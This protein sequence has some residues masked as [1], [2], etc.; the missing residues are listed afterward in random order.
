MLGSNTITL[1]DLA[2]NTTTYAFT[3]DNI[4]PVGGLLTMKTNL[5]PDGLSVVSPDANGIY[6][7]TTPLS[8]TGVDVFKSLSA[9][10]TDDNLNIANVSV[11]VDGNLNGDMAYDSS[12]K[13]WN[14]ANQTSI[15]TFKTGEHNLVATFTDKAG[16]TKTLTARFTTDNTAPISGPLTM[17][18]KLFPDG[19]TITSPIDG[20]YTLPNLS[21]DGVDQ[22]SSLSV[23][24]TDSNLNTASVPVYIDGSTTANGEMVYDTDSGVWNYEKQTSRPDFSADVAHNLVATFYDLAGNSTTLTARFTTDNTPPVITYNGNTVSGNQFTPNIT[25]DDNNSKFVWTADPSNHAGATFDSTLL[26]PEFTVTSSGVYKFTLTVTDALENSNSQDVSFSYLAPIISAVQSLTTSPAVSSQQSTV[27]SSVNND[28]ST[29][30]DQG[31]V[32][33]DQTTKP[34]TTDNSDSNNAAIK[35]ASTTKDNT[36]S[37]FGIAW[38]WWLVILAAAVAVVWWI[39]A[40]MRR[41]DDQNA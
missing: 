1:E 38:Y 21:I 39:I 23:S 3:L 27:G 30:N 25:I 32:L 8:I 15:A 16:N 24:L 40:A 36:V 4:A 2:G 22:F 7:I 20:V 41:R 33:G 37:I 34:N 12:A 18:T 10:V 6:T 28:N 14:Y 5:H 9:V 29:S 35:G 31:Q 19:I 17:K 13:V 26:T 11:Y